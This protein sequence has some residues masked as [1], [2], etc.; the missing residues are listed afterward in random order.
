MK[1]VHLSH[2][3][4][5]NGGVGSYVR[6]LMP[7]LQ[8]AGQDV[9]LIHSEISERDRPEEGFKKYYVSSFDCGNR[10]RNDPGEREVMSLLKQVNPDIVHVQHNNNFPLEA[11]IRKQF[12][13][14]KSLHVHDFCPAGTK[15]HFALDKV[16]GHATGPMCLPRMIYKRCCLDKNPATLWMFYDRA[17]KSI[18]NDKKTA[19]IIVA[20]EFVKREAVKS[21]Y[22][23]D[24]VQ[25]IPYF[26]EA[27][28]E[29]PEGLVNNRK[30]ILAT[31]RVVGEKGLDRLLLAVTQMR[32]K[33]DW[34]LYIDGDG[35]VLKELKKKASVLKLDDR[36][37]F[38]GW[39]PPAQHWDLF[40]R[41][42]VVVVPSLWPEPFGLVGIE[43]MSFGKPVIAFNVGGIPDWL[44]HDET[45]FL[46]EPYNVEAM[47]EKID[48]LLDHPDLAKRLGENGR[49]QAE[50][51]FQTETHVAKLL[52][53]YEEVK[54]SKE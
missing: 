20:S 24:Q 11:E 4:A 28:P 9:S 22:R 29:N 43:A 2:A 54:K 17:L 50:K 21:G 36:V 31:G 6:R 52:R 40:R 32:T 8:S 16:C 23:E 10:E 1:I 19:R 14:V 45:G 47:A 39:L 41:S 27:K 7:A 44:T 26:V 30:T 35:P 25:V 13:V 46:I 15:F 48:A 53:V 49:L 37:E 42:N 33:K 18:K 38:T 34:R 5:L 3:Y 51:K 12:P